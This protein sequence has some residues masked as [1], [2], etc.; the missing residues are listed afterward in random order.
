VGAII[1][2]SYVTKWYTVTLGVTFACGYVFVLSCLAAALLPYRAK[3]LYEASPG[4]KYKLAGIPL[5]TIFGVI[6]FIFGAAAVVAFLV[7]KGYG[8]TGTSPYLTYAIVAGI[9]VFS[10]VVYWIGRIYQKG[11]GIDVS[12]AFLEVPPE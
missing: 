1:G 4:A 12:Y 7:K 3:A 5:V 11:K 2:Y 9:F 6:G 10:L 8:L